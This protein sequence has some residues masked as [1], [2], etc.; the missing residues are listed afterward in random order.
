MTIA[1]AAVVTKDLLLEY[2]LFRASFR[3]HHGFE[4]LSVVHC[5][6]ITYDFFRGLP[7]TIAIP[8][9]PRVDR[10][11]SQRS[12]EFRAIVRHKMLAI[13]DAWR[14]LSPD[15]VAY[16]DADMVATAPFFKMF[17]AFLAPLTLSPH[18]WGGEVERR[19]RMY[20]FYN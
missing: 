14:L 4:P 19:N 5:D 7:G 20:G 6:A 9:V 13:T 3:I 15:A 2:R 8:T 17:A 16:I 18:Y 11:A 10:P 12:S 1:L